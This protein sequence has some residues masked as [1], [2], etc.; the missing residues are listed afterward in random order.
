MRFL[1][2]SL[3][4]GPDDGLRG[5]TTLLRHPHER[6][7]RRFPVVITRQAPGLSDPF[8]EAKVGGHPPARA[9]AA[10]AGWQRARKRGSVHSNKASPSL[11][12]GT[13]HENVL[14]HHA[15]EEHRRPRGLDQLTGR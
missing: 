8:D 9:S 3:D 2:S 14:R 5:R 7:E 12:V 11:E 1:T 10:F 4:L 15:C 13:S 6:Q